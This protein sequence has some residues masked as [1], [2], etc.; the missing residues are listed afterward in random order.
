MTLLDGYIPTAVI[1]NYEFLSLPVVVAVTEE[2]EFDA[3]FFPKRILQAF[4]EFS[5]ESLALD[6]VMVIVVESDEYIRHMGADL[7]ELGF[8]N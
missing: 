1:V 8:S 2:R 5:P 4:A 7:I 6:M 3:E